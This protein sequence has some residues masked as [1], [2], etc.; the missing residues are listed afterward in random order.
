MRHARSIELVRQPRDEVVYLGL[1][2]TPE[3]TTLDDIRDWHV[4]G[5]HCAKCE[6]SGWLVRDDVAK[7]FGSSAYLSSLSPRLRCLA[8]GNR[9]NNRWIM[10]RLPR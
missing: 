10:G 3:E 8:C 6:R 2:E 1:V 9:G 4:L 5:G 7:R